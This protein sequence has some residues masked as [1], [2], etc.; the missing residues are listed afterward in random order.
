MCEHVLKTYGKLNIKRLVEAGFL[1]IA[2][3]SDNRMLPHKQ[4]F[5]LSNFYYYGQFDTNMS[6]NG[7][8]RL[9]QFQDPKHNENG[10]LECY[11]S[12]I[13][14][15][16]QFVDNKLNGFGRFIWNQ[17]KSYGYYIGWFKERYF[18]GYGIFNYNTTV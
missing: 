4:K 13:I 7:I 12:C 15:E 17:E 8:G 16:G 1:Q 6:M 5:S 2:K 9:I 11:A 3:D 10:I 14:S 18:D